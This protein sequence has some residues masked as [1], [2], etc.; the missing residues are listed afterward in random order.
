MDR[1]IKIA[2]VSFEDSGEEENYDLIQLQNESNDKTISYSRFIQDGRLIVSIEDTDDNVI[3]EFSYLIPEQFDLLKES[4]TFQ[5]HN[6]LELIIT[7]PS[8]TNSNGE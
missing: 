1:K 4:A 5:E 8:K 6:P 2:G 7:I 3:E